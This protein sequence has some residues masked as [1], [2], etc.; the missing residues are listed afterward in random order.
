MGPL[1]LKCPPNHLF[2]KLFWRHIIALNENMHRHLS[3]PNSNHAI[4]ICATE[5]KQSSNMHRFLPCLSSVFSQCILLT[6]YHSCNS[7]A[8][9]ELERNRQRTRWE[10]SDMLFRW[11]NPGQKGLRTD[12]L[13][14]TEGSDSRMHFQTLETPW[15]CQECCSEMRAES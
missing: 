10:F 12:L 8:L 7:G 11:R 14:V 15:N 6:L 9:W 4:F 3:W 5:H 1:Q 13:Y 2:I